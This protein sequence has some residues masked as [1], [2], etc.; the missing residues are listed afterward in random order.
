MSCWFQGPMWQFL[1]RNPSLLPALMSR[2]V[3][4]NVEIFE[5][6]ESMF[7]QGLGLKNKLL[8]RAQHLAVSCSAA[9]VHYGFLLRTG[10]KP[11]LYLSFRARNS[12]RG[13]RSHRLL[14]ASELLNW[15]AGGWH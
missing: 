2:Q 9:S 13:G 12:E 4:V 11:Y 3:R 7:A 6:L 14:G 10:P 8:L 15:A 1:V 5:C